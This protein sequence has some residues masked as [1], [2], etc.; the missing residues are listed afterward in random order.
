MEEWD[1]NRDR[2]RVSCVSDRGIRY[3][4]CYSTEE[5]LPETLRLDHVSAHTR[6]STGRENVRELQRSHGTVTQLDAELRPQIV[7]EIAR[8]F[9]AIEGPR[10]G[11]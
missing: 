7:A 9:V 1:P 11:D 10:E 8:R 5:G 6:D 2:Y 3:T 4:L